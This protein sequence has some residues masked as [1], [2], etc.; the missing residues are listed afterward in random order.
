VVLASGVSYRRLGIPALEALSGSG[1][2]YGASVSEAHGLVGHRAVVVGGGNSAGQAALH[3]DRYA[4]HVTLVVRAARLDEGMSDYLVRQIAATG[5]EVVIGSRVVDGGG[6]GRLEWLSIADSLGE[7]KRPCDGLFVMI[8]ASPRT[9]WLP[10]A[11]ARDPRGY[12]LA[13]SDLGEHWPLERPPQPYETSL[14]GL[15][16][17]GDVRR[18]SVK[19]VA[20]AVGEGS[21]VVS[22]VHAY[23][24]AGSLHA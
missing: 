8:G 2:F 3:L 14:P 16:A 21:V 19:R 7:A 24:T 13:G 1:V 6:H 23:L 17:V 22:Q 18:G 20:S 5:I 9:D 12:V 4:E 15:F 11:V 10:S